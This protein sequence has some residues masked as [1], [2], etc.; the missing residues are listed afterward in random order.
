M[1]GGKSQLGE[2]VGDRR[3]RGQLSRLAVERDVHGL[4]GLLHHVAACR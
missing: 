3:A 4:F 2:Q 1:I